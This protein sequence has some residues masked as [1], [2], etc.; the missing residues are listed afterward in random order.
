MEKPLDLFGRLFCFYTFMNCIC[1]FMGFFHMQ[2]PKV[3]ILDERIIFKYN[4][5]IKFNTLFTLFVMLSFVFNS[6]AQ[7][8][9][10]ADATSGNNDGSSWNN[11]FITLQ[12]AL[13]LA[14]STG[15][16]VWVAE[17]TYLPTEVPNPSFSGNDR[18]F[19]FHFGSVDLHVYGGFNGTETDLNQRDW[20]NN[21]TVLSGDFNGDDIVTGS[22]PTLSITNNTENTYAVFVT[23]NTTNNAIIDGFTI[24]SGYANSA[25]YYSYNGIQFY[26]TNGA[27]I[28]NLNSS[29]TL[30]NLIITSCA[31]T[32]NGAGIYN[33]GSSAIL[34][35]V[36]LSNNVSNR[37]GGIYN[38][39]SS[40]SLLN[41]IVTG[42]RVIYSTPEGAGMANV[43]SS[44]VINN[45]VFSNNSGTGKGGGMNNDASSSPV[46]NNVIFYANSSTGFGGGMHNEDSSPSLTN[47][48][49]ANNTTN[50]YGGGVH[51]K[52]SSPTLTNV[53]F[54]NNSATFGGG[55]SNEASG[56]TPTILNTLF[57]GNSAN[58][59]NDIY[60]ISN[61]TVN[62]TYSAFE[63]YNYNGATGCFTLT[64]NPF[65]N[66]L[67]PDGADDLW[68][69]TDDGLT[70]INS[71]ECLGAGIVSGAPLTD[72]TGETRPSVPSIGAYD[73]AC[74][75]DATVSQTSDIIL[76]SNENGASYVWIDCNN[77]NMPI[78]NETNQTF[79][80]TSNGSYAVIVSKN[81]CSVTSDCI[82]V[83]T[84]S[85]DEFNK[86]FGVSIYPNPNNGRFTIKLN[87]QQ[88]AFY[89]SKVYSQLGKLVFETELNNQTN[90]LNIDYLDPGVYSIHIESENEKFISQVIIN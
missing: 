73:Q 80:A 88:N 9:V 56:S 39:N 24:S 60:L 1:R 61:A 83:S 70:L 6:N 55:I 29:L 13:D 53:T 76:T 43:N 45:V 63:D 74:N 46:L 64:S 32:G 58:V 49:F 34:D 18:L 59:E 78:N 35:N 15:D 14:V 85:V 23:A 50:N 2:K 40:I 62:A 21:T 10:D 90:E 89:T 77:G 16:E 52:N 30:S 47:V 22:G 37:G 42:N 41:S 66:D 51:N 72:I 3:T 71:S 17:G 28:I 87:H 27:G 65:N 84:V 68:M 4:D 54:S 75:L 38:N 20:I 5:M 11:A 8:Y 25:V 19:A 79:T 33:T 48:V 81:G 44:P 7:I 12:P 26:G 57:Y 69:T 82:T 86:H 31:S 36:T 67:D